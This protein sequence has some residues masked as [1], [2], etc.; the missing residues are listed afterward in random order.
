[1]CLI[2][3]VRTA[4]L[5]PLVRLPRTTGEFSYSIPEGLDV[6]VG[7]IVNATFRN[8]SLLGLVR[9]VSDTAPVGISLKPLTS[10]VNATPFVTAAQIALWQTAAARYGVNVSLICR[11]GLPPLKKTKLAK[12]VFAP[13]TIKTIAKIIPAGTH[14]PKNTAEWL[15]KIIELAREKTAVII[16]EQWQLNTLYACLPPD[17]KAKTILWDSQIGDKE[18]FTN[19]LK[20]RTGD[21][22]LLLGTRGAIFLPLIGVVNHLVLDFES[23]T[24]HKHWDQQPRF[25]TRDV[26]EWIQTQS[27]VNVHYHGPSPSMTTAAQIP[28]P[29]LPPLAA[30]VVHYTAEAGTNSLLARPLIEAIQREARHASGDIVCLLNRRGLATTIVCRDCG[31]I[32]ECTNCH[33]PYM[34]DGTKKK[35]SCRLCNRVGPTLTSCPQCQSPLL[36]MRGGG[37]ERVAQEMQ[38]ILADSNYT[39]ITI[40]RDSEVLP[41]I[42][43]PRCLIGT[44]ALLSQLDFTRVGLATVLDTDASLARAE[45]TATANA[46]HRLVDLRFWLPTAAELYIQTRKPDHPFYQS[47]ANPTAFYQAELD[48]RRSLGYPPYTYLV[49]YL[50]PGDN[51]TAALQLAARLK[52]AL[53]TE[54]KIRIVQGP[55]TLV[56]AMARERYWTAVLAKLELPPWDTLER[57]VRVLP[58]DVIIDPNPV[59][60][61]S[62][63]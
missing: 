60:M 43:G 59:S 52:N 33:L 22:Q 58:P 21:F 18:Q 29:N 24:N 3:S 6:Q 63:S 11:M 9:S 49:R 48:T 37:T 36:A 26:A 40:D 23:D 61:F 5:I 15:A 7:Q 50:C 27:N 20:L 35:L 45:F 46:W 53:T 17:L 2:S 10:I 56:P 38:A 55:I 1:M 30:T 62:L 51:A 19:W 8:R 12:A 4:S 54:V 14:W 39:I 42:D 25:H 16:P 44:D 47:L 41:E 34:Y 32:A 28:L 31:F 13:H 57:S